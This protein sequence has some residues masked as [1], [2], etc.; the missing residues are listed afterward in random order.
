MKSLTRNFE[1][2]EVAT[3][4]ASGALLPTIAKRSLAPLQIEVDCKQFAEDAVY[5]DRRFSVMGRVLVTGG[6]GDNE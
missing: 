1:F 5:R 3:A 4:A 6:K 2:I